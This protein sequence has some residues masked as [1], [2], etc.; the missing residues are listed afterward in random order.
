MTRGM[1]DLNGKTV[2]V[3]GASSGIGTAAAR[4]FSDRGCRV[5]LAARSVEKL[6]ALA[7]ELGSGGAE[8]FVISCDIRDKEQAKTAVE[9]VVGRWGRLDILVN[10]A[11]V[12]R[13]GAFHEQD[14]EVIE[15]LMRTNLLG[16][17]YASHAALAHMTERGG[18]HVVN[19]SSIGGLMGMPWTAAY[20]A[21][22][23][24][25]VGL[26]EAL[27][28]E[29]RGTGIRLSAFCPGTVD[30]PMA[31]EPL[32]DE[33]L[34]R[35]LRPKTAEGTA[36]KIVECV[37]GDKPELVYGE[38]PGFLLRLMSF[39]PRIGDWIVHRNF[40]RHHPQ[41]RKLLEKRDGGGA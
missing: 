41:V 20:S 22:K 7:K 5:A 15:D 14:I 25:M 4:A 35:K 6:E 37:L 21:S 13:F 1:R 40:S 29:Y 38:V 3:T 17:I 10:N 30:T 19:V 2:L 39:F 31:A 33:R 27:R 34:R 28:R 8:C 24:G 12:Q 32:K 9:A 11:G 23:F 18:G 36:E 16:A 26:T